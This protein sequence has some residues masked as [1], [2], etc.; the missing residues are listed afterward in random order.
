MCSVVR[1]SGIAHFSAHVATR[2][3]AFSLPLTR[4]PRYIS[5]SYPTLALHNTASTLDDD[6]DHAGHPDART[7]HC[8]RPAVLRTQFCP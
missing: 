5:L 7:T 3:V 8:P 1:R 2:G 6:R 4:P